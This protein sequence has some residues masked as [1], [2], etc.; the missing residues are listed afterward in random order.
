MKTQ[1]SQKGIL[2][3]SLILSN[4]I[5]AQDVMTLRDGNDL[6]V[7]VTEI[8]E[9][10][11]KYK[12]FK[13]LDGPIRVVYKSDVFSIKYQN[14]VKSVFNT[15]PMPQQS[16]NQQNTMQE[17]KPAETHGK[18]YDKDTS[19]F[20]KIRRKSFSGPRIGYTYITSGTSADYL[21]A[22]GKNPGITQFG[23]QFEGRLFTVE[24]LS[25]LIEFVPL[26]GGIEQG[27]IIPSASCLLGVRSSGKTSF[28]FA[29]G[30]NFSISPNYKGDTEGAVGLVLAA[31]TSLKRGNINFPI[32][33]VVVPSIGSKHDIYDETSKTTT[34]QSFQTGWRISLLVGFNYIKK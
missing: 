7:K 19:D 28:E 11:I 32:N 16:T 20:A 1:K 30:P 10:E 18:V 22:R 26:I 34:S 31:G 2:A 17:Y 12:D 21:A 13:N 6:I 29:L 14:G 9:T 8:N 23:W 25:G 15:E 27:I 24:G 4:F 33:L 3:L 5:N